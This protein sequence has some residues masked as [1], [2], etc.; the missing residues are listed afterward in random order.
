MLTSDELVAADRLIELALAE[1]LG[2]DRDDITSRVTLPEEATGSVEIVARQAGV[3]AGLPIAAR[4]FERLGAEVAF[5][6]LTRDGANLEPGTAVAALSGPLR[7]LLTGE[8]T[9][10]NFLTLLSGVASLTRQFVD[11]VEGTSAVILDTRKTLP[12]YR[13]L[14]KY[15]VRKG[16]GTNHRMGLHDGCLIKDNHLAGRKSTHPN[17]SLAEMLRNVRRELGA[18]RSIEIEV[19]TLDQL[20][21]ALPGEP[22]IV[23]LDN[24]PPDTLRTAVRLRDELAPAA[25]LEASGGVTLET[26]RGIAEAGVD[27]IS[28]GGLTHSAPALDLGFDWSDRATA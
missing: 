5:E 20:R 8:R 7:T 1:D 11:R 15:A 21:E 2:P 14:E 4:V 22:D 17:E 28:I 26:V 19:D 23:L 18:E 24:M 10:L 3:L 16:G 6:M 12:G 25:L 27:R 13:L 9:A